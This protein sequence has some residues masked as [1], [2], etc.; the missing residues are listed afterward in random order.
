LAY[1]DH[2]AKQE[3]ETEERLE[4]IKLA[5][6]SSGRLSPGEAFPDLFEPDGPVSEDDVEYDYSGVQWQSPSDVG[7]AEVD[8][9]MAALRDNATITTRDASGTTEGVKTELPVEP[10]DT[11][12]I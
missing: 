4:R 11:E 2:Q 3:R 5:L 8:R 12:W 7:E 10:D 9:V 1:F 6:V